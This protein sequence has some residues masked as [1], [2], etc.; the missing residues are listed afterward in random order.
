MVYFLSGQHLSQGMLSR[1]TSLIGYIV[2]W[3][4]LLPRYAEFGPITKCSIVL[5][6]FSY[7]VYFL[8]GQHLSK[9][10]VVSWTA[11]ICEYDEYG[12]V[13]ELQYMLI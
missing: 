13:E 6:R 9:G 11:L 4:T 3:N 5:H 1:T 10:N 12:Y 7:M 2:L 8:S